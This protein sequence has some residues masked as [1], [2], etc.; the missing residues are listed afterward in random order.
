MRKLSKALKTKIEFINNNS[1]YLN[2]QENLILTYDGG[3]FPNYIHIEYIEANDKFVYIKTGKY[4]DYP[5]EKRYTINKEFGFG[6][7]DELKYILN[8]ISKEYKKAL[9]YI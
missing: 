8:L 6:S 7:F 9:K 5:I 2:D 1:V 4:N 3:T